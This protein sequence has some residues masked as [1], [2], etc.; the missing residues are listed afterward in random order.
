MS[1][2]SKHLACVRPPEPVNVAG[3]VEPEVR[4][5]WGCSST[6]TCGPGRVAPP[7]RNW[8]ASPQHLVC[9]PAGLSTAGPLWV[10]LVP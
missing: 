5:P 9:K 8:E 10:R 6:W 7:T 4:A 2:P 3:R 1:R